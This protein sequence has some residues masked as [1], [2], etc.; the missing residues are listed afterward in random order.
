MENKEEKLFV[1][2]SE[3]SYELEEKRLI[4]GQKQCIYDI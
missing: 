3:N 2:V 4:L 1:K